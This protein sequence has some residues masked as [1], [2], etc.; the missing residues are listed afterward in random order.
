MDARIHMAAC[1]LV[2]GPSNSGK[3]LFVIR[4]IE[5]AQ[6]MFDQGPGHVYWFYGHETAQQSYL[7]KKNFIVYHGL[8][9]NLDYCEAN[10]IIVLDDLM[11]L[12]GK[13]PGLTDLF[14]KAA[15]HKNL[16]VIFIQQNLLPQDQ[17][18]R[19]RALNSQYLVLFK[20]PR[21]M[22]QIGVLGRQIYPSRKNYLIGIYND[23]T[24][25]PHSYLLID[26]HQKTP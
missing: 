12:A 26:L 17:F 6:E 15:H 21:D 19:T 16:L 8:P 13:H 4:L 24:H 2:A 3:T 10:S 9:E 23:A 14:T 1:M 22:Q 5:N 11:D 20:S 7:T 25:K 18:A